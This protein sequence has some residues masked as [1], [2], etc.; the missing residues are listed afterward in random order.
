[1]ARFYAPELRGW[2]HKLCSPPP[3]LEVDIGSPPQ[4]LDSAAYVNFT[5]GKLH[6]N[7][8]QQHAQQTSSTTRST[9]GL[10]YKVCRLLHAL[11]LCTVY[12]Q[13]LKVILLM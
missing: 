5:S 12:L 2:M 13:D 1:M 4:S 6:A 9:V 3:Q 11:L 10:F 7:Q 8:Q